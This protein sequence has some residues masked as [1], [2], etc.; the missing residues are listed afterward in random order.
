MFVS[1]KRIEIMKEG[2]YFA[3]GK[4]LRTQVRNEG[5]NELQG[6]SLSKDAKRSDFVWWL[7]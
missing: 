7:I 1:D 3:P 5:I 6:T 2:V 4:D